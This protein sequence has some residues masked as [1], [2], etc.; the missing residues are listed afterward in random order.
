[1]DIGVTKSAAD[2]GV[3]RVWLRR[4][5]VSSDTVHALRIA[6][7]GRDGQVVAEATVFGRGEGSSAAERIMLLFR[8]AYGQEAVTLKAGETLRLKTQNPQSGAYEDVD[9]DVLLIE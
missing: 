7:D 4:V 6:P 5:P 1:M 2:S 9:L 8:P 3:L